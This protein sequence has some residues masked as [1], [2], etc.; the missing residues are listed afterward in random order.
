MSRRKRE[1]YRGGAVEVP[2]V[3]LGDVQSLLRPCQRHKRQPPLLL[4]GLLRPHLPGGEDPLIHAAEEHIGKFQ[5]LG[6][7]NGHQPHLVSLLRRVGIGEQSH[8]GQI[9]L[10]GDL[11]PAGGLV[12][13]Y[14]LLQLRRLS[15]RSWLPSVRS[16]FS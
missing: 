12:L 11:L 7:V 6:G 2:S 9:V 14:R 5:A 8:M 13:I 15:S 1:G 10:Q 16:I 4:H 3:C